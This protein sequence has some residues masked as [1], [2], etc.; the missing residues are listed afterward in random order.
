[1]DRILQLEAN[2]KPISLNG[3]KSTQLHML[4]DQSLVKQWVREALKWPKNA[5]KNFR[6]FVA[7]FR[8]FVANL[9]SQ[10]LNFSIMLHKSED[11]A[12]HDATQH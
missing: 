11:V 9:L 4:V 5:H 2:L 10:I 6:L 1:M 7:T 12:S 3:L 8:L